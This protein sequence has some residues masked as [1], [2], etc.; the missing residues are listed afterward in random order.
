MLDNLH[1]RWKL[2]LLSATFFAPI[3]L[4]TYL[5]IE[6]SYR[7]IHF[8]R[9]ELQGNSYVAIVREAAFQLVEGHKRNAANLIATLELPLQAMTD[10]K[11]LKAQAQAVVQIEKADSLVAMHA[12]RELIAKIGD[13]TKLILDPDLDSYYSMSIAVIHF[14]KLLELGVGIQTAQSVEQDDSTSKADILRSRISDFGSL[15]AEIE[16][17]LDGAY[18]GNLDGSLQRAF[19]KPF[20]SF[21]STN[22]EFIDQA[23]HARG[24]KGSSFEARYKRFLQDS[25]ASWKLSSQ[26][27]ERLLQDRIDAAEDKLMLNLG[28]C[29]VVLALAAALAR[30]IVNSISRPVL[31]LDQVMNAIA[32]GDLSCEVETSLR[33]DEIGSLNKS[34]DAMQRA[35]HTMA[36]Q[37]HNASTKINQ[38]AQVM[39]AAVDEQAAASVEVNATVLE[40]TTTMEELSSSSTKIANHS[41]SVVQIAH[42]TWENSKRGSMAMQNMLEKMARIQHSNQASLEEILALGTKSKEI[43]K[44]M[45]IINVI[46]DQTKLIAFNAAIE[47]STAGE[48]GRRFGVVAGEIRRLADS[49]TESTLEIEA[50]IGEI[51]DSISRLVVT[52]EKGT[53][54]IAE[55]IA[56]TSE[57]ATHLD[58]LVSAAHETSGSAEQIS[59]STQQQNTASAQ[60][61]VALQEIVKAN[62]HSA[63]ALENISNISH[64]MTQTA[65]E[66][67]GVLDS[68]KL[69]AVA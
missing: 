24:D 67:E 36:L 3:A 49:V 4:T 2:S 69:K 28:M 46:A 6:Q 48:A 65:S 34:A 21:R 52:S 29:A 40:I 7:D 27:L 62:W 22:K 8:A 64:E 37:V 17:D 42:E 19:T 53:F 30:V 39:L 10:D 9:L 57:T 15:M 5:L 12:L 16:G 13:G 51:Q 26:E 1:I 59:L 50:R 14:P 47:A 43:S 38:D 41:K 33:T 44:V 32:Q 66:L 56:A 23:M 63:T 31:A 20:A 11:M 35:M 58:D 54:W 45:A 60:V 18:R 61:V 55:G 68:F 25:N